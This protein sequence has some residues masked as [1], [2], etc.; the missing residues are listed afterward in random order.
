MFFRLIVA[1]LLSLCANSCLAFES[2]FYK[3][4]VSVREYRRVIFVGNAAS[5]TYVLNDS[6]EN[7]PISILPIYR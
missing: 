6:L 2:K 1:A 7:K 5:G 3:N 4:F